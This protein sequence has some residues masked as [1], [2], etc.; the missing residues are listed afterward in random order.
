MHF[1]SFSQGTF[2]PFHFYL[3]L[4]K[5]VNV[6]CKESKIFQAE[7]VRGA[8]F[9][10][11]TAPGGLFMH[12]LLIDFQLNQVFISRPIASIPFLVLSIFCLIY[13]HRIIEKE[14][15]RILE[16]DHSDR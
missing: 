4:A 11:G 8:G 9:A 2:D 14:E 1:K 3:Q 7:I 6:K 15:E 12:S 10:F 5:I 13:S 16:N